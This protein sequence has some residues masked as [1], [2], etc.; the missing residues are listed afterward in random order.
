[1][2]RIILVAVVTLTF[3]SS[4]FLIL[5]PANAAGISCPYTYT[6]RRGDTLSSIAYRAGTSVWHL[7]RVNGIW[8]INYIYSGRILC[9]P[10]PISTPGP[11]A[12]TSSDHSSLELI[13][14]HQF[15]P[16]AD[17]DAKKWPL[18]RNHQ[19]GKRLSFTLFSGDAID[20]YATTTELSRNSIPNAPLLWLAPIETGAATYT[21]IAI[22]DP[23]PLLEL[24]MELA[25]TQN[26]ADII[27]APDPDLI[28]RG[29][30]PGT[31]QPVNKLSISGNSTIELKAQF[32]TGKDIFVPINISGIDYH[33]TAQIAS[34]C[35]PEVSFALHSTANPNT[36]GY[37]LLMVFN[38]KDGVIGPP[39]QRWRRRCFRWSGGGWWSRWRRSWWGC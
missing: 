15:D 7:A 20:S 37:R 17:P 5:P 25:P 28:E 10:N 6:V 21:L 1:M 24:Q 2:K 22:A 14:T 35:Y 4:M 32:V 33:E 31:K 38:D 9:I 18:G 13:A 11:I 29:R 3:L 36:D 39:G 23:T 8:N 34:K 26:I 30:C 19:A 16:A 12:Q 27:P